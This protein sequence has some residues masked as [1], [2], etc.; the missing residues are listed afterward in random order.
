MKPSIIGIDFDNTIVSY[1]RIMHRLAVEFGWISS[2]TPVSKKNVRDL[3]RKLDDG[4]TK[5]QRMQGIVY[6]E[7]MQEADLLDGVSLFFQTCRKLQIPVYIVSHKT[8][9]AHFDDRETGGLRGAALRW[10]ESREFFSEKGLGLPRDSVF[11]E[12]TRSEKIERIKKLECTHF[13]DDLEELFSDSSFP[14][15]VEKILFS[16][17]EKIDVSE[18]R[19]VSSW[20]EIYDHFF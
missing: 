20:K 18:T 7:K 4:E 5:W 12:S 9:R 2:D 1:D 10:M 14:D 16:P 6:Q 15:R 11:F 17:H 3:I 19:V 13:V 8:E